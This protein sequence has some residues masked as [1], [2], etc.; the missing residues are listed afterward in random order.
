MLSIQERSSA[1]VRS[2]AQDRDKNRDTVTMLALGRLPDLERRI[3]SKT[4]GRIRQL[5]VESTGD[6]VVIHG[7]T[8]TYYAKQ[9]ATQ[10]ILEELGKYTLE[11]E[12]EVR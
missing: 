10:I 12:I 2:K 5:E 4:L 11:N 3:N 7:T 9:L 6:A 1:E 8:P